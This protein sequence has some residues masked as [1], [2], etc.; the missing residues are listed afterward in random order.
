MEPLKISDEL[1][2]ELQAVLAKHD[3]RASDA[4]VAIQYYSAV[5]GYVLAQQS[6]PVDQKQEFLEQLNAFSRHVF[7]DCMSQAPAAQSES[8]MG[9]WRPGDA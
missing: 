6:F 8:A 3:D 2:A 9:K 1:I 4:G 7:D 5:I